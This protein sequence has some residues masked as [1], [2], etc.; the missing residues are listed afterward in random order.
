MA[1]PAREKAME[2][3]VKGIDPN[4]VASAIGVDVTYVLALGN[5]PVF[6]Q[7]LCNQRADKVVE[8]YDKDDAYDSLETL[9]LAQLGDALAEERDT[10]T[11][12][13]AVSTLN[14]AKR[15][16]KGEGSVAPQGVVV[17]LHLPSFVQK[18]N[19]V[20]SEKDVQGQVVSVD[21]RPLLTKDT[22]SILDDAAALSPTVRQILDASNSTTVEDL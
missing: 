18:Y 6:R 15:R 16:S 19:S 14:S 22:K 20:E 21:G 8:V 7:T 13:K 17:E 10:K 2:M 12:L 5:D 1:N 3:L 4:D 11:L 9:A